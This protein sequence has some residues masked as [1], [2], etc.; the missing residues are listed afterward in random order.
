MSVSSSATG[1]IKKLACPASQM[2]AFNSHSVSMT[3][4]SDFWD[5]LAPYHSALENS[6]LDLPS[7]RRIQQ[8]IRPP[9]LVVGAGLKQ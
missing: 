9:V 6:F 3:C 2:N 1:V 7:L 4:A 5:A 8:E